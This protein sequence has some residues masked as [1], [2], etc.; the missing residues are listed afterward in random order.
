[1][2]V[3]VVLWWAPFDFASPS[4]GPAGR[5]KAELGVPLR[6]HYEL[7]PAEVPSR[8]IGDFVSFFILALLLRGGAGGTGV[9]AAGPA[10]LATVIAAAGLEAGQLFLPSRTPDATTVLIAAGAAG[11][12]VAVYRRFLVLA[13]PEEGAD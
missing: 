7:P 6:H 1:M 13:A 8:V 3:L 5:L 11:T 10:A 4:G 12:A 2:V 9:R